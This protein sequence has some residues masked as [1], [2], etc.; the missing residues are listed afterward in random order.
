MP[1]YL[2]TEPNPRPVHVKVCFSN[3]GNLR[4]VPVN[5]QQFTQ[6]LLR[7]MHLS[8]K[9][10]DKM[11]WWVK[12]SVYACTVCVW[13]C[14]SSFIWISSQSH[15]QKKGQCDWEASMTSCL[16][17]NTFLHQKSS[18]LSQ[19]VGTRW[20]KTMFF[21]FWCA[22]QVETH[23]QYKKGA[24]AHIKWQIKLCPYHLNC[25]I[26]GHSYTRG[27]LMRTIFCLY[28]RSQV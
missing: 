9:F 7:I 28:A 3:N 2:L 16:Y 20:Q 21:F 1:H 25:S 22:V 24:C 27:R 12:L 19:P 10:K 13:M 11:L 4:K 15:R 26:T 17:W 18:F 8:W 23:A 14:E 5:A 6:L